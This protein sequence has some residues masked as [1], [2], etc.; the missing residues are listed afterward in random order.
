MRVLVVSEDPDFFR[1]SSWV[2]QQLGGEILGIHPSESRYVDK[3]FVPKLEGAWELPLAEFASTLKPDVVI[4]GGTKRD[5]TF[6]FSLAGKL[7]SSVAS[8]VIDAKLEGSSLMVRRPVYSGVGIATLRLK[9]P[10]VIT[11]QK[12]T[13]EPNLLKG[14]VE[15][16]DLPRSVI[17]LKERKTAQQS[18]S[19]DKAKIIVSVGRG[20]GS[21]IT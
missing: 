20:M 12:N 9:L 14:E 8:D 4:A 5:R 6:A 18:V 17:T 13:M 15:R 7:R 10:A 19:L 2:A 3:V 11:V 21:R 1:S 16:V